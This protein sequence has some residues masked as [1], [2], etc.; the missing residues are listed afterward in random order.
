MNRASGVLLHITSLPGG[1]G[2]GS[3]GKNA[4]KW[5]DILKRAGQT[6][7]QILPL[8]PT[9]YGNSPYQS[10]STFAG[11]SYLIDLDQLRKLRLL[12]AK[13]LEE[14]PCENGRTVRFDTLGK[15][16]RQ[17]LKK[18]W[19]RG[20]K[21]YQREFADFK[22]SNSSWLF[23]YAMFAALKDY[24]NGR[25]LQEW[26]EEV[27]L[28][29]PGTLMKLAKMLQEEIEVYQFEQFVFA[30]Q[31]NELK[32][33]ANDNGIRIIGDLPIYVSADSADVWTN[34]E[35]FNLNEVAGCPPDGYAPDGQVW[36]NPTYRWDML[37]QTGYAWWMMRMA[38]MQKLYD[39]VR[40]DHFRGFASYFAVPAKAKT[41]KEG[42]WKQGP[43]KGLFDAL[44]AALGALPVIAE[45]LG[46]LTQEVFDL[47]AQ[48]GYPG[49]KVL[50]FAFDESQSSIYLPYQYDK[51]CVVYTGTHDNDTAV[52]WYQKLDKK[53]RDFF[54]EYIGGR[55]QNVSQELMRMAMASSANLCILLAQDILGL[56]SECRMNTPSTVSDQNWSFRLL[57]E[58]LNMKCFAT[59]KRWS[60]TYGRSCE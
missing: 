22:E 60:R 2:I 56:G 12:T 17:L 43:G 10:I 28:R 4:Y 20:Q 47:L 41:A 21:K 32:A 40:L 54:H 8:N 19:Q 6:Y 55:P 33:Y 51:N 50:E 7:W 49:T 36:G 35:I 42:Q 14:L 46:Y 31:W 48:C 44:S 25:P 16:R 5:V 57:D 45:D 23:D 53:A 15:P 24:Y 58:E 39:V 30:M 1:Y 34:P 52:G 29:E 37:Q 13:E 59:L 9:G 26:E 11:N 27:Q 18:A 38:H 3:L